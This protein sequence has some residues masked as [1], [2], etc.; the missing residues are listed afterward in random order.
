MGVRFEHIGGEHA[1][2]IRR[3]LAARDPLFYDED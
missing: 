3:F 2:Q 1:E